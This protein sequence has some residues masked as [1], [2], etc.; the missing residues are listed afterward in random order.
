M[1]ASQPRWPQKTQEL[2]NVI[3]DSTRWNG[4]TFRDDDIVVGTWAKSG[5]TLTQ[6]IVAQLVFGGAEDIMGAAVSP[7]IEFRLMDAVPIADA[8]TH[9]RILKTHLPLPALV[10]SPKAK[11][12][13]IGRDA[14]DV[15]WSMH[16]HHSIFTAGA[17]VAF[18][19]IPDRV[20]PPLLP[21]NPDIRAYYHEW[22][23]R[24]G[25]PFWPFWSHVQ[26]WWD[27]QALPNVL[28]LHFANLKTDLAGEV[29][30]IAEFLEIEVAASTVAQVLHHCG[31]EHMRRQAANVDFLNEIFDGGGNTFINKGTNGRWKDVLSPGEIRKCDEIAARALS[32]DCAAWLRTGE[33]PRE[34]K[35]RRGNP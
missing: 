15:L 11:Y 30:R 24:D 12:I 32:A 10:F 1:R 23:D 25:H 9:R 35:S 6:Q 19:S 14:R 4:F 28:L 34:R 21:P 2:R 29:R 17:Y 27:A 5:T 22:L 31:M 18:N 20:G 13:Y 26:G 16:H 8:Q 7:W 3:L 33:L